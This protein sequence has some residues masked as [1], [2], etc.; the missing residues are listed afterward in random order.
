MN[1]IGNYT[2]N[3]EVST[4]L[5]LRHRTH[6][7]GIVQGVNQYRNLIDARPDRS[8]VDT[9]MRIDSSAES[10]MDFYADFYHQLKN[11]AEYSFF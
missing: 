10:F 6:S 5:V 4:L 3:S 1:N 2:A 8:S 11:P 9:V 7:I